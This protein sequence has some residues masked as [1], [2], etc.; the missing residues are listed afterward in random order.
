MHCLNYDEIKNHR[1]NGMVLEKKNRNIFVFQNGVSRCID[2][3]HYYYYYCRT[4]PYALRKDQV[5]IVCGEIQA[6]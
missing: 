2:Y 6:D 5:E 4:F 1:K 3:K